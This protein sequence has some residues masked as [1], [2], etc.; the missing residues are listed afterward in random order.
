VIDY[1]LLPDMRFGEGRCGYLGRVYEM[2]DF[3]PPTPET[4]K[5]LHAI[6]DEASGRSGA[7]AGV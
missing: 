4:L 3:N 7:T 5:R 2:Q 1:E 6:I